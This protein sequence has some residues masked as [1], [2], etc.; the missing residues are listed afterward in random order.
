ML[1]EF[2]FQVIYHP[3]F[4]RRCHLNLAVLGARPA[5]YMHA[6]VVLYAELTDI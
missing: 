5:R 1:Q 3:F 2:E 4:E 6:P